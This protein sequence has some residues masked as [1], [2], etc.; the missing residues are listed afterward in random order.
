VKGLRRIGVADL[1]DRLTGRRLVID[2]RPRGDLSGEHDVP[3]LAEN[4]AGDAAE[5]VLGEARIQDRI[6][7]VVADL[8]GMPLRHRL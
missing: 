3:F 2:P 7:H 4:L 6:G 5:P 1:P 8:V